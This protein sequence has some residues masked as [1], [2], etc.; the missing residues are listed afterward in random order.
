MDDYVAKPINPQVLGKV[1]GKWLKQDDSATKDGKTEGLDEISCVTRADET[2]P[3]QAFDY[4]ALFNRMGQDHE[5]AVEIATIYLHDVPVKIKELGKALE[6][7]DI[8]KALLTAHSI[9]GNSANTAC[10]AMCETAGKMEVHGQAGE[11]D[12]IENLLPELEKQFELCRAEIE[13]I[14]RPE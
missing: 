2:T 3:N 5:L 9:K 1:L 4:Q 14:L 13:K 8:K 7:K 12:E 10:M 6:D 11:L